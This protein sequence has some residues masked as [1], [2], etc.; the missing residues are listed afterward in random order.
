M[1]PAVPPPPF[2]MHLASALIAFAFACTPSA[3][4]PTSTSMCDAM[5]IKCPGSAVKPAEPGQKHTPNKHTATS[6]ASAF[7]SAREK[8]DADSA[9]REYPTQLNTVNEE[10][11]SVAALLQ[12]LWFNAGYI[13]CSGVGGTLRRLTTDL[14][15]RRKR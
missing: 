12:C 3:Y 11:A 2:A 4:S 9:T 6:T 1:V 10:L 13:K 7:Q 15:T 14:A 8:T 5:C